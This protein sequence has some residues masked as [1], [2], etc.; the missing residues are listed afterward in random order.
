M[1]RQELGSGHQWITCAQYYK[2]YACNENGVIPCQT[3]GKLHLTTRLL[4]RRAVLPP[5]AITQQEGYHSSSMMRLAGSKYFGCFLEI[6]IANIYRLSSRNTADGL[7][8]RLMCC[9]NW[10]TEASENPVRTSF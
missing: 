1:F 7:E 4:Q 8:L 2:G 5:P 10:Q 9:E 3:M 6:L